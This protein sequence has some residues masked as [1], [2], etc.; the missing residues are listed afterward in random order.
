MNIEVSSS[1]CGLAHQVQVAKLQTAQWCRRFASLHFIAVHTFAAVAR[2]HTLVG[3]DLVPTQRRHYRKHKGNDAGFHHRVFACLFSKAGSSV[4][5]A[6][7]A[8]G[9]VRAPFRIAC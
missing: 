9:A 4:H 3:L 8:G 6:K 2:P 1:V 5:V 7:P